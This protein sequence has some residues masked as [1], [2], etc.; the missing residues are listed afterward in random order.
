MLT[1]TTAELLN[2]IEVL[3]KLGEH[4]NTDADHS[5]MQMSD[6]RPGDHNAGRIGVVAIETP[7]ALKSSPSSSKTGATNSFNNGAKMFLNPFDAE[8]AGPLRQRRKWRDPRFGAKPASEATLCAH[9]GASCDAH[10]GANLNA[11]P[12]ALL[13]ANNCATSMPSSI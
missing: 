4:I 10:F 1:P 7:A 13:A 9:I 5:V 8:E 11:T 12:S 2:A 6:T 3:N